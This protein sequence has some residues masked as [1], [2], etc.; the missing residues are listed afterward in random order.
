MYITL[1]WLFW[2][3]PSADG[4]G[5]LTVAVKST[6][7][8]GRKIRPFSCLFLQMDCTVAIKVQDDFDRF[9]DI[10]CLCLR[11]ISKPQMPLFQKANSPPPKK[12]E[13]ATV[14]GA[15]DVYYLVV[16]M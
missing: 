3:G 16:V 13:M 4:N 15:G 5:Q 11:G 1:S 8:I 7:M 6:T 10:C 2:K 14:Y 12:L 9:C